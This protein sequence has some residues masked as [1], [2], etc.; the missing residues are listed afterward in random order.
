LNSLDRTFFLDYFVYNT[1]SAAGKTVLF[2]DND[3]SLAYSPD[4]QSNTGSDRSLQGTE[5]V[6][7][8]AGAWVALSF[9][10]EDTYFLLMNTT[11]ILCPG[12][13]ISIFGP[14]SQKGLQASVVIDGSDSKS[15]VISQSKKQ[16]PLFISAVL[17][18][19]HH[20]M[21]VTLLTGDSTAIDYFLVTS[22]LG[23]PTTATPVSSPPPQGTPASDGA[24]KPVSSSPAASKASNAPPIAAI[25][26]GAVGG[27]ALLLLLL[28][29]VLMWR[30]RS[31]RVNQ[32]GASRG[33]FLSILCSDMRTQLSIIPR[34]LCPIRGWESGAA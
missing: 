2:D 32:L 29:A 22:N 6:S 19:G 33:Y 11:Q 28:I 16:N 9:E 25:V 24:Q 12:T 5:H 17:P 15:G 34:T 31:R 26:G 13:Q 18:L 10:G 21:N 23:V 30:R 3:A 4:W 27:L 7:T 20:T 14:S 8:A 1:A